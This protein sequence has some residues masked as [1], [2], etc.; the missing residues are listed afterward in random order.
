MLS[1]KVMSMTPINF[2]TEIIDKNPKGS[3]D[4]SLICYKT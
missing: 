4:G 2:I 3:G 1:P